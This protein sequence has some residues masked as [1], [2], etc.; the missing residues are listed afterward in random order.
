MVVMPTE[1]KANCPLTGI[2]PSIPAPGVILLG[3]L[4]A[5]LVGWCAASLLLI[6]LL[7]LQIYALPIL[8]INICR[9]ESL[10]LLVGATES[11]SPWK[12]ASTQG[13]THY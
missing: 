8:L 13:G 10:Y 9:R 11:T 2:T 4:G 7:P 12:A 3:P 6:C 1:A 5:G